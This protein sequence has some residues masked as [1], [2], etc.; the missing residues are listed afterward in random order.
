MNFYN[1]ATRILHT[2]ENMSC[3]VYSYSSICMIHEVLSVRM[4]VHDIQ[5]NKKNARRAFSCKDYDIMTC[6]LN[7]IY[8]P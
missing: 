5:K 8:S 6:W 1:L 2:E 3:S 4:Q 7:L